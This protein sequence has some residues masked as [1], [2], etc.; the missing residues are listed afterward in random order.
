MTDELPPDVEQ[1][2]ADAAPDQ[3]E[4][5]RHVDF[6]MEVQAFLG[7]RIGQ[8]LIDRS[9][10]DAAEAVEGLKEVNPFDGEA[11]RLLQA[12]VWRAESF[13]VWLAEA[14]QGGLDSQ[15]Q[16]MEQESDD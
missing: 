10:A 1:R 5:Y 6:G 11:V 15:R 16:L 3:R 4:L 9:E 2:I 7:S 13:Q 8:F 14:I 12:K